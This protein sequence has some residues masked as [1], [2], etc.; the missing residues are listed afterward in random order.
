[1]P[2]P[3][4]SSL[5]MANVHRTVKHEE[6]VQWHGKR[7]VSR[8]CNKTDRRAGLPW[9]PATHKRRP[10]RLL[11]RD[12]ILTRGFLWKGW[13]GRL[14]SQHAARWQYFVQFWWLSIL[15]HFQPLNLR[16]DRFS[17]L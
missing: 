7:V 4:L 17:A 15:S 6:C 11:K 2:F 16:P 13:F 14:L 8:L 1:M 5:P 3:I 12:V 10:R 9:E